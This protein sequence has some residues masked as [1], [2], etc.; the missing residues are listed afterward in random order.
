MPI[1]GAEAGELVDKAEAVARDNPFVELR[2]DY[3][4]RPALALSKISLGARHLA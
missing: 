1:I 4:Q 2:L 3:L